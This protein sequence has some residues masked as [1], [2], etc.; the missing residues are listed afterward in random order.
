MPNLKKRVSFGKWYFMQMFS[1]K[2]EKCKKLDAGTC[3][4]FG[5]Y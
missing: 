5:G 1:T 4:K 3:Q 2:V